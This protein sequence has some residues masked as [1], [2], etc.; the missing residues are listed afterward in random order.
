MRAVVQRVSRAKVAVEGEIVGEI[1]RGMLVLLGVEEKDSLE[2][3]NYLAE[4]ISNLRIFDDEEGKMNLSLM[5]VDGD[6]LVVS[7]FTLYGDCRKGRRPNYMMA[8]KPDYANEMYLKF[9][10]ECKKYVGKVETGKFQAKMDV[11]L[12]NDG[13]VTLLLDSKKNF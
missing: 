3:V 9:V 5:D 13:P 4:K 7:Q 2:D 10:N 1:G 8:A 6:M 11:E 12:V